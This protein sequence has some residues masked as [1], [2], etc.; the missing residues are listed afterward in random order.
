MH[1]HVFSPELLL[2]TFS[3]ERTKARPP[4]PKRRRTMQPQENLEKIVNIVLEEEE[5][6]TTLTEGKTA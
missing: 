2:L 1:S 3:R 6:G 5:P 4:M